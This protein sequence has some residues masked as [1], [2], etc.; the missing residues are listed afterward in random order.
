MARPSLVGLLVAILVAVVPGGHF[1]VA[2]LESVH[3]DIDR[4]D[5]VLSLGLLW[6][7]EALLVLFVVLL[8]HAWIYL[9]LLRKL[10]RGD[11]QFGD[12]ALFGLH[13]QHRLGHCSA[14][15]A[16]I[17]DRT[18]QLLQGEILTQ[19]C[20]ELGLRDALSCQRRLITRHRKL[21]IFLQRRN[22]ADDVPQLIITSAKSTFCRLKQQKALINQ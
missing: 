18:D 7:L 6:N 13:A 4:Q 16:G 10:L 11:T 19:L 22:L 8:D 2:G 17:A 5:N 21:A 14:D 3:Q 15:N 9:H 20:L 1:G 12:L